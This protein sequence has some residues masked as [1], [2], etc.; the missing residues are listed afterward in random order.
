[1]SPLA[2]LLLNWVPKEI[3]ALVMTG[4]LFVLGVLTLTAGIQLR[5]MGKV[6]MGVLV[7]L[8]VIVGKFFSSELSFTVKGI[9]FI[10][11]GAGFFAIN[12][13]ASRQMKKQGEAE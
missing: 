4:F 2:V 13:W 8:A 12:F 6:N 7:L 9:V 10:V 3:S 11:C 5:A 1:V